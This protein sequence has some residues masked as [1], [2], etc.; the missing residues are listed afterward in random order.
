MTEY[1]YGLWPLVLVNS[2]LFIV[3][4]AEQRASSGGRP[5]EPADRRVSGRR[6]RRARVQ[7]R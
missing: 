3:F 4:A 6:P 5:R 1:G 2:L 7:S